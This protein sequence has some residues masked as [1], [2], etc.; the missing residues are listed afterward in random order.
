MQSTITDKDFF[1]CVEGLLLRRDKILMLKRNVEPFKGCWGIVGGHVDDHETVK[2]A[3][4][5]EFKE[6]TNLNVN[7]G[8]LVGY[9][10]EK[11]FDRKKIILIFHVT[12]TTGEI[13]L[14]DENQEFG[15]FTSTPENSV[16]NYNR[17]INKTDR[18][19]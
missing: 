18:T 4:R 6:E 16:Y 15:W 13:K 7:V 19:E 10:V 8:K 2:D 12:N 14:N 1:L 17:F 5:R 9:H 3:L 11:T